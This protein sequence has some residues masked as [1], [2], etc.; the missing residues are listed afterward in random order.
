VTIAGGKLT[1]YRLIAAALVDRVVGIL[2]QGG[3]GRSFGPSRTGEVPLPGGAAA[4][5]SVAAA[6]ISRDGH[7]LAPAVI[8]HL[9]DRYGSRL[10]DVLGLVAHDRALASP[11]VDGLPD[12]RAEI[13]QAVEREWALTLDDV[14]RRRTQLA[15]REATGGVR[16]A[17][18]VASLMAG[19]LGWDA[20]ATRAAVQRYVDAVHEKRRRW[21]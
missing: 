1:T 18:E 5:A 12:P 9:A 16:V 7:G 21:Q 10:G 3:D 4:P 20:E 8:H 11:I 6:A 13:A 14:L 15:L 2:K 19:R 17:D